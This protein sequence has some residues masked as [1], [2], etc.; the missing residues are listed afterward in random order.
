ME[1]LD[2]GGQGPTSGCCAIEEDAMKTYGG[3]AKPSLTS[4]RDTSEWSSSRPG[5]FTPRR[6]RPGIHC[7]G[8]S[9]VPRDGLDAIK[10]KNIVSIPR[11]ESRT[12]CLAVAS[13][14]GDYFYCLYAQLLLSSL[15][16][17]CLLT[18]DCDCRLAVLSRAVNCCWS[19]PAQS[20]FVWSPVRTHFQIFVPSNVTY[21][22]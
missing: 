7:T 8:T 9:V 12:R 20:F 19:S 15:A 1:G 5:H 3:I 2:S 16:G 4:A 10:K 22:F 6:N 14:S 21:M 13:N 11:I 17:D 18:T